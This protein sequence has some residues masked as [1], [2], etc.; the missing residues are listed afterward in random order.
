MPCHGKQASAGGQAAAPALAIAPGSRQ[1]L[2]LPTDVHA[3]GVARSAGQTA[4]QPQP[5]YVV[6]CATFLSPDSPFTCHLLTVA[7]WMWWHAAGAA[8]ATSRGSSYRDALVTPRLQAA[9]AAPPEAPQLN[10][11]APPFHLP[12]AR[13][14]QVQQQSAAVVAAPPA[15]QRE[16]QVLALPPAL[17]PP[18]AAA[19]VA[20]PTMPPGQQLLG[21]QLSWAAQEQHNTSLQ[22]A[23]LGTSLEAQQ[24]QLQNKASVTVSPVYNCLP[25]LV[26]GEPA[27]GKHTHARQ[28]RL[29]C[30]H[31]HAPSCA[32]VAPCS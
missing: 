14:A 23:K 31:T 18:P 11:A 12:R 6:H 28:A 9:P 21:R 22:L 4:S 29:S 30:H 27:A 10:P 19:L 26:P 32:P 17:A 8:A 3:S 1:S 5:Q 25:Q 16:Q 20:P 24:E 2:A 13:P 15:Q 7:W